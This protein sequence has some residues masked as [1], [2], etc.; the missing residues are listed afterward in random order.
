M[1]ASHLFETNHLQSQNNKATQPVVKTYRKRC[2]EPIQNKRNT[3]IKGSAIH[4]LRHIFCDEF[5]HT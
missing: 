4:D 5:S 2:A 3:E 1:V